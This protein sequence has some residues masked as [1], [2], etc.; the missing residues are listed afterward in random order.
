MRV[1]CFIKWFPR[2]VIFLVYLAHVSVS[3]F[4][5]ERPAETPRDMTVGN[6]YIYL[7]TSDTLYQLHHNLTVQSA[8]TLVSGRL[9]SEPFKMI[10]SENETEIV[11]CFAN[12][13]CILYDAEYLFTFDQPTSVSLPSENMAIVGLSEQ[14]LY[15]G[16][17]G[18]H[19]TVGG[20]V[21]MLGQ[22][23]FNYDEIHLEHSRIL[24]VTNNTFTSRTFFDAVQSGRYVYFITLDSVDVSSSPKSITA[25][26]VCHDEVGFSGI[27]EIALDCGRIELDATISSVSLDIDEMLIIGVSS[28][29]HSRLCSFAVSDINRRLTSTFEE[30]RA[31]LHRIPLPWAGYEEFD[32]SKFSGVS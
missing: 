3:G 28:V 20:R 2:V 24:T 29:N 30:C 12:G 27:Y 14:T 16:S 19:G 1:T 25:M 31:G 26:R 9:D 5:Y 10:L 18:I 13:Q 17:E 23:T 8:V 11:V 21:I 6:G 22:Y 7:L 32:C 15:T 4:G